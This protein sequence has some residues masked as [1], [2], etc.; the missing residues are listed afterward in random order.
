MGL[1]FAYIEA[2]VKSKIVS[3]FSRL[4]WAGMPCSFLKYEMRALVQVSP[5]LVF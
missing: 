3:L 2:C 4:L 1:T 5:V